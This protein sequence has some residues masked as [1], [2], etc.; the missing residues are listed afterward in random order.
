MPELILFSHNLF[1]LNYSVV[2]YSQNILGE[3]L[4]F[5][6][7]TLPYLA[8]PSPPT[9]SSSEK[10]GCSFNDDLL[11]DYSTT[12][13]PHK[14][15][16]YNIVKPLEKGVPPHFLIFRPQFLIADSHR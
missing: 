6:C 4:C 8:T 5:L 11:L 16:H 3:K 14:R 9:I 12:V 7:F 10:G 15:V 1:V 13:T 2:L